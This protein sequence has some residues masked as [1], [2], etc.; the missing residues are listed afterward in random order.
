MTEQT[1]AIALI[2]DSATLEKAAHLMVTGDISKMT[3][4]QK[5]DFLTDLAKAYGLSP[6]PRPFEIIPGRNGKEIIYA[7]KS[8]TDQ[9]RKNYGV[10]IEIVYAGLLK[11]GEVENP[12]VYI[13]RAKATDRDGRT[14]EAIG[15]IS[16]A[17][18]GPEDLANATMKA[19]TKAKRRVTLS[20][21]G[22][23]FLDESEVMG[24]SWN[25]NQQRQ[26]YNAPRQINPG[27]SAVSST[28]PV[29]NAIV[30]ESKLEVSN[31][32]LAPTVVK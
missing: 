28:Q 22:L 1:Q 9:L 23:S 26:G 29:V 16:L 6:F 25:G 15:S 20:V 11:V 18:L 14:D 21:C 8:C 32:P 30:V 3:M 24:Q 31:E 12:Q 4:V 19:E 27:V 7:N 2:Q 5:A 10:S 13:V 17:G